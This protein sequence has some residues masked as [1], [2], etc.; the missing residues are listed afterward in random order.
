MNCVGQCI[1]KEYIG[2][3]TYECVQGIRIQGHVQGIMHVRVCVGDHAQ[4]DMYREKCAYDNMYKGS[5]M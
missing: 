1:E 3:W 4:E 2:E 5:Y